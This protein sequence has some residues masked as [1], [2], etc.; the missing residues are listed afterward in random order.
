LLVLLLLLLL[1][2]LLLFSWILFSLPG[3]VL[4]K[5]C[6]DATAALHR[7]IENYVA[8]KLLI[9]DVIDALINQTSRFYTLQWS[10]RYIDG[11]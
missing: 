3:A 10:S 4:N 2:V 5:D 11:T 8:Q 9:P 1:L 6:R 7:S